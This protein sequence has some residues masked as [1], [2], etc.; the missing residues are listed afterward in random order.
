MT[1]RLEIPR[2]T[3]GFGWVGA[4]RDGAIGWWLP[5]FIHRFNRRG[6]AERPNS[7]LMSY[8]DDNRVYMCKITIEPVLSKPRSLGGRGEPITRIVRGGQ[9]DD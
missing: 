4:W 2:K 9:G 8:A 7:A 3:V 1:K 5:K 6:S